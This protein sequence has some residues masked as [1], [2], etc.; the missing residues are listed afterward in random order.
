MS[1][2]VQTVWFHLT[3]TIKSF[4]GDKRRLT[5]VSLYQPVNRKSVERGLL[6]S[7]KVTY[8]HSNPWTVCKLV[9]SL[10]QIVNRDVW[11]NL[12][13]DT[14]HLWTVVKG[15]CNMCNRA[16]RRLTVAS[17]YTGVLWVTCYSANCQNYFP[18]SAFQL[19]Q[20][21]CWS[22][23]KAH[24]AQHDWVCCDLHILSVM[25]QEAWDMQWYTRKWDILL[26]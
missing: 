17:W 5:S 26:L 20:W 14:G 25:C 18:F 3:D 16:H 9:G 10:S 21:M 22:Q 13:L 11:S 12:D 6:F 15:V 7:Q 4:Q 23:G 19:P 1:T 2:C 24:S 8:F